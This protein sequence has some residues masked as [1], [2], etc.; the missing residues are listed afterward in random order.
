MI[1]GTLGMYPLVSFDHALPCGY[2]KAS[3]VVLE[4]PRGRVH[5][6]PDALQI[7]LAVGGSC[8]NGSLTGD[9]D[10]RD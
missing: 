6:L 3:R 5:H 7:R 8:W 4:V 10:R 1:R 2:T 9:R